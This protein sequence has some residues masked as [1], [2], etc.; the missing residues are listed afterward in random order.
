[1]LWFESLRPG[2]T[3][4]GSEAELN[5]HVY[6]GNEQGRRESKMLFRK[7]PFVVHG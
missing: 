5:K 6:G 1:M 3:K 7:H 2:G 4:N